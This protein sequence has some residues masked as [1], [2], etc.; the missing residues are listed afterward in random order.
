MTVVALADILPMSWLIRYICFN[1][2]SYTSSRQVQTRRV[3]NL[4]GY[5][6][7]LNLFSTYKEN[8]DRLY[9]SYKPGQGSYFTDD[10]AGMGNHC[11]IAIKYERRRI[12]F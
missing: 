4:D 6:L 3:K 7:C 11:H 8:V 10:L 1:D 5:A 9:I 2:N 12:S